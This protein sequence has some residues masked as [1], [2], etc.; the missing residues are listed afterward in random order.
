MRALLFPE[1]RWILTIFADPI[2]T[3]EGKRW[4]FLRCQISPDKKQIFWKICKHFLS[5]ISGWQDFMEFKIPWQ[6]S[7]IF[8]LK[9]PNS[10]L[11]FQL[12]SSYISF[13]K[14]SLNETCERE[15]SWNWKIALFSA[16]IKNVD[17]LPW[18]LPRFAGLSEIRLHSQSF[19]AFSRISFVI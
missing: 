4:T 11:T 13:H 5:N 7:D 19:L 10:S 6:F 14:N 3:T 15:G 17:K 9:I 12:V 1:E 18:F 8:N 2:R 16:K